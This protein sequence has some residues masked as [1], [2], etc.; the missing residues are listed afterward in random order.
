ME[1]FK[2]GI[3]ISIG[4]RGKKHLLWEIENRVGGLKAVIKDNQEM[5]EDFIKMIVE[6]SKK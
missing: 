5:M 2:K 1:K 6:N 4:K 3:E